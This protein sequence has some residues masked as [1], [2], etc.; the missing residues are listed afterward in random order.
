MN[1]DDLRAA[2]R[3]F[4]ARKKIKSLS[5]W[6]TA[7]GKNR[8]FVEQ[9]LN[10]SAKNISFSAVA[11]LAAAQDGTIFDILGM[12]SR[13]PSGMVQ[14]PFLAITVELGGRIVTGA[15]KG[16]PPMLMPR[17]W[18]E[19]H[20]FGE[21]GRLFMWQMKVAYDEGHAGDL[22]AID[23]R[24][25]NP[26]RMP[27]YYAIANDGTVMVRKI[28]PLAG[29]TLRIMAEGA[30]F[31]TSSAQVNIIGRAVWRGGDI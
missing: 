27:G 7:A 18:L 12:K 28:Q 29:D 31:D 3:A 15:D 2:L 8:H 4:M 6:S 10:G 30:P 23:L 25:V 1:D 11:D 19:R 5:A 24:T 17:S 9:Y 16:R 22:I 14:I 21:A 20:A 13:P 26:R